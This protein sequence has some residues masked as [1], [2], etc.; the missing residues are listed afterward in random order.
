MLVRDDLESG[1]LITVLEDYEPTDFGIYAVYPHRDRLPA[2]LR[3]F[4]DHLV[5]WSESERRTRRGL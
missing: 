2:K 5:R 3:T 1:R 4:I